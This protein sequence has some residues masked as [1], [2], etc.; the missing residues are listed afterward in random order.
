MIGSYRIWIHKKYLTLAVQPYRFNP[1]PLTFLPYSIRYL[2][3][4]PLLG[5]SG[6]KNIYFNEENDS[7]SVEQ[8]AL[9]YYQQTL[10]YRGY[11]DEGRTIRTMSSVGIMNRVFVFLITLGLY[12][13]APSICFSESLWDTPCWFWNIEF[14]GDSS[15]Y[16]WRVFNSVIGND[17]WWDREYDDERKDK[18]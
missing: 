13:L 17:R 11:H 2:N 15:H 9:D 16:S 5:R 3:D 12:I 14:L 18:V 10:H 4:S 1:I 8:L 6:F 7:L